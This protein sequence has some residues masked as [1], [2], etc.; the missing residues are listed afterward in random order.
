MQCIP[1]INCSTVLR[2]GLG[3]VVENVPPYEFDCGHGVFH[4]RMSYCTIAG[5]DSSTEVF[6]DPA[7]NY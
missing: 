4:R 5:L 7:R 1:E 6:T 2:C 3:L